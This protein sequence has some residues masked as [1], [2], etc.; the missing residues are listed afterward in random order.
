MQ[1]AAAEISSAVHNANTLTR[2]RSQ[3]I[4]DPTPLQQQQQQKKKKR[5]LQ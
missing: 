1:H 4:V 5:Q 3:S 2:Q